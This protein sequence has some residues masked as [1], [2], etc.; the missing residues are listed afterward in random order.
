MNQLKVILLLFLFNFPF[1]SQAEV[2]LPDL[3]EPI[4]KNVSTGDILGAIIDGHVNYAFLLIDDYIQQE[5]R[6]QLNDEKLIPNIVNLVGSQLKNILND[7]RKTDKEKGVELIRFIESTLSKY[8]SPKTGSLNV[9]LEHSIEHGVTRI[10]WDSQNKTESCWQASV[11]YQDC[12]GVDWRR[13]EA[14]PTVTV[15]GGWLYIRQIPDYYIYRIVDNNEQLISKIKGRKTTSSISLST[16]DNIFENITSAYNSYNYDMGI[17][18]GRGVW[19]DFKS[20][21]RNVGDTLSYKVIS[22]LSP[23]AIDEDWLFNTVCGSQSKL[24]TVVNQDVDSDGR[25]DYLPNS[26]YDEIF[27]K[28]YGWLVPTAMLLN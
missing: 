3:V 13:G 5:I 8:K 24:T 26:A 21:Y 14:C 19:F 25:V 17:E 16:G 20:D 9:Q 7:K 11:T 23:Y 22:D 4:E 10:T 12:R 18:N 2:K 28:Y 27:G 15:E 6:K 1:S